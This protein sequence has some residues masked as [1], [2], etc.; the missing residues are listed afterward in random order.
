[1]SAPIGT[2]TRPKADGKISGQQV[3]PGFAISA[4]LELGN[5]QKNPLIRSE[6]ATRHAVRLHIRGFRVSAKK[7]IIR[8]AGARLREDDEPVLDI[9]ETI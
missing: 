5:T 2:L 1:M 6:V 9:L 4:T 7:V 8:A 3:L